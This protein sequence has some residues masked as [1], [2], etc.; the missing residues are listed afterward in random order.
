MQKLIHAKTHTCKSNP[1][2]AKTDVWTLYIQ[3]LKG[4]PDRDP[5]DFLTMEA[6]GV[7]KGRWGE[8]EEEESGAGDM[9]E[10]ED[11]EEEEGDESMEGTRR[12]PGSM[13][14]DC[15]RQ[16]CASAGRTTP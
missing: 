6:G 4:M 1:L 11:E 2:H 15:L 5:M 14:L 10:E 12:G 7:A 13:L 8:E 3:V 9:D 16:R